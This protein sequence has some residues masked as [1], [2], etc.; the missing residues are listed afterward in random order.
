MANQTTPIHSGYSI[1]NG[2]FTGTAAAKL[3]CWMEYKVVSQSAVDNTSTIRFYIYIANVAGFGGYHIYCNNYDQTNRGSMTVKANG[4][5]VYTR[6][7]RGFATDLIPTVSDY[8]TQYRT[9]YGNAEGTKFLTVMTDNADT[10]AAGYGTCVINHNADGTGSVTLSWDAD[11]S[12]T[13]SLKLIT[14]SATVILPTID[15]N[16]PI[17]TVQTGNVTSMGFSMT[18][19]SSTTADRWAYSLNSGSW[20][21]FS[22]AEGQSASVMLNTLSTN[23]TYAVKVRAK[24]KSNQVYG[25]SSSVNVT[26]LGGSVVNSVST[27]TLDSISAKVQFNMTVYN[28]S[29]THTLVISKNGTDLLTFTNITGLVGSNSR[30]IFLTSAQ[31]NTLMAAMPTEAQ[32]SVLYTLHT[33][34]SSS[35]EIGVGSTVTGKI[36]ITEASAPV[37]TTYITRDTKATTVAVTGSSATL[38]QNQSILRV[39]CSAATA[40]YGTT[41]SKYRAT[42]GEKT[43]ESFTTTINFGT[44]SDSGD[45]LIRVEAVDARGYA[46][47]VV[48][49]I[50]V[51]P[52]QNVSL[53]SWAISRRNNVE[54]T[55]GVS[56]AGQF[57]SITVNGVEKNSLVGV[58]CRY[59]VSTAASYGSSQTLTGTTITG[60]SFSYT[61][62]PLRL[63]ASN[64]FHIELTISDSLTSSSI[65]VYVNKGRPLVA[66]RSERI[67]INTNDPQVALDVDGEIHMN[68]YPVFGYMDTLDGDTNLD[69]VTAQGIYAQ[70][71]NGNAATTLNYPTT[72]AGILEVI[73]EPSGHVI[74]RYTTYD[75]SGFYIRYR[76]LGNW[77]AWKSISVS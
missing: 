5:T 29:Y 62:T 34:N 30:S 72:K 22:T 73:A 13:N 70:P 57:S 50:T 59:K 6:Q 21:E 20:V 17:V 43:V 49:T 24:R 74:Q 23:T 75:I 14:G 1:I 67:G 3:G 40:K 45:V 41:I 37:F 53:E 19:L 44:I 66:F 35:E 71:Q 55:I 31:R 63:S 61:G 10:E 76:F 25:A 68:G 46:T 11:C 39:T 16:P 38:I 51:I 26:T 60:T 48:K 52:Y 56:F 18:A 27:I 8:T 2:T 77:R 4:S 28:S 15:R 58:T 69:D 7:K 32:S 47:T 64:A 42:I 9:A 36:I 54:A 65:V 12:F 33:Y